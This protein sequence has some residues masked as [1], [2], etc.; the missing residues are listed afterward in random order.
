MKISVLINNYNYGRFLLEAVE[1]ALTQTLP[2]DEI[3]IVDDGSTDDS[4]ARL[5]QAY[6]N[7]PKVK[8][9]CQ[10][11]QGQMSAVE[12][13]FNESAGDII[14]LLDADDR[15]KP[16]HLKNCIELFKTAPEIGMITTGFEI[17]GNMD[18]KFDNG[19]GSVNRR[20]GYSVIRTTYQHAW[21]CG[22]CSTLAIRRSVMK[23]VLPFPAHVK[24]WSRAHA[25]TPIVLGSA[26]MGAQRY[27]LAEKTVEYHAHGENDG[28]GKKRSHSD[29]YRVRLLNC[30][31]AGHY[32]KKAQWS[33][34]LSAYTLSEFK[35]IE[36]PSL[37][38]LK[39]YSRLIINSPQPF[40]KRG[41]QA[42]SAWK[43]WRA[44]GRK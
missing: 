41:E 40:F 14:F 4:K 13:A 12:V 9:V 27:Y 6:G 28:L 20:L 17:T 18:A 43:Y 42:L 31:I 30:T 21:N 1:S 32:W 11:N 22:P 8:L 3:I 19:L 5:T 25:D 15:Y 7:N 37:K 2:A 38:D 44:F 16:N 33:D 26:I 29:D 10:E 23:E 35:T 39:D 36:R 24:K 34:N